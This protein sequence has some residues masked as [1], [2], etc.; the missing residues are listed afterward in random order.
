MRGDR[1]ERG[2][3]RLCGA[4]LAGGQARRFGSDKAQALL[5][6][7]RLI[8][9]AIASLQPQVCELVICGRQLPARTCI[10]DRPGPGLGPLGGLAGALHHA[11]QH[12]MRAVL[13]TGCDIVN[14]PAD[15]ADRLSGEGAAIVGALPVVGLW[16]VDLAEPLDTFLDEGGRSLYAF[17]DTIG[18]RRITL[19]EPLLNINRP[20]DLERL[21]RRA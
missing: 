9:R 10:A 14:L 20:E 13:S 5:D 1:A 8:D 16:P 19:P 2:E 18:A 7:E 3:P 17:A 12:D 15:I 4:I 6:G 21:R 11:R